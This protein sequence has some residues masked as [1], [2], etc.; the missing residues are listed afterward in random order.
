M[1]INSKHIYVYDM[2]EII[3]LMKL[4]SNNLDSIQANIKEIIIMILVNDLGFIFN[5]IYNTKRNV[6]NDF[7]YLKDIIYKVIATGYITIPIVYVYNIKIDVYE[8]GLVRVNLENI[9]KESNG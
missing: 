5:N 9:L 6:D 7:K 1:L 2:S 3:N 8:Q 4:E